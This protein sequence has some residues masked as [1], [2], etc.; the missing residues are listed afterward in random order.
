MKKATINIIVLFIITSCSPVIYSTM[1]PNTPLPEGKGDLQIGYGNT[2]YSSSFDGNFGVSLN[3]SYAFTNELFFSMNY[4]AWGGDVEA[5]SLNNTSFFDFNRWESNAN[6]IEIGIGKYWINNTDTRWR[7]EVTGGFGIGFINNSR[8]D[9]A[10]ANTRYINFFVQ[11]A[12]GFKSKNFWL[13]SS[14]KMNMVHFQSLEWKFPNGSE[15]RA[16]SSFRNSN[17]SKIHIE[18]GIGIGLHLKVITLSAK[19]AWSTFTSEE[20]GTNGLPFVMNRNFTIS[21]IGTFNLKKGE[22]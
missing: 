16:M 6:V 20:L 2:V 22:K 19:Y 18:P 1:Q 15:N 8:N 13:T 3:G 17:K 10:F 4:L 9:F 12:G 11:P 7:G 14:L 21:L 5:D